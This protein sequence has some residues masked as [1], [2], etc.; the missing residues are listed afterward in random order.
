MNK[1][2]FVRMAC[3]RM[4]HRLLNYVDFW[5]NKLGL[6]R[7]TAQK[8]SQF[9]TKRTK[10]AFSIPSYFREVSEERRGEFVGHG[11]NRKRPFFPHRIY[12][13]PKAGP[14]ALKLANY[15]CGAYDP[16]RLWEVLL[17]AT[18]PQ[19]D[20]FPEELFFDDELI[21]HQQQ[22]GKKGH[23]AF[24]YLLVSKN[25]LYGLNYISDLV[26]RQSKRRR[27]KN[28]FNKFRAWYHL[29][30]N[31][32]LSFAVENNIDKVFSPSSG[33]VMK[34]TNPE[35]SVQK[36]LFE[37]V[38]DGSVCKRFQATNQGE[39]WVID[40]SKN[41]NKI[42]MPKEGHEIVRN[43]KTICLCHD[44]ERGLGHRDIDQKFSEAL[45]MMS[46]DFL[47]EMLRI[48]REMK[49]RAT[50][51]VV[52]CFLNEVRERIE[53]DGHCVA[54]HSYDHDMS[55]N[56]LKKCRKIGFRIRGYRPPRSKITSEL[57][58]K[59]LCYYNFDWIASSGSSLKTSMPIMKNRIVKIPILFDDFEMHEGKIE[60][61]EWEHNAIEK[62]R[63]N[64]FVAFCLHDCYANH[65]LAHYKEFLKKIIGM[66][67]FKT[68]DEVAN[69][70]ILGSGIPA[71]IRD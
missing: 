31:S 30:L 69:D 48:E 60:Y 57:N 7:K 3:I 44:I 59:N 64:D 52:G 71:R 24:A 66:G 68:M 15:M 5:I 50:Y 21:W 47:E 46:P 4:R 43:E 13:L 54:F 8:D 42:V 67:R 18:H 49:V 38:Y 1:R 39:W 62:I 12:Y 36:R 29:L 11:F 33:L 16:N 14:E 28:R 26:Q 17:F 41:R 51:N 34:Y 20:E 61:G 65:W 40:V 70:M 56:Q 6:T 10:W 55:R 19:I 37:R 58:D 22:F 53:A 2:M 45:N 9:Q 25:K 63:Q 23:V 27:Y 35:V 32:I